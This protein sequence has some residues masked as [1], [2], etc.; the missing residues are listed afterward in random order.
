MDVKKI[1]LYTEMRDYGQMINRITFEVPGGA[2]ELA[3]GDFLLSNCCDDLSAK[4]S[5]GGISAVETA[6]DTVTLTT[7]WFLYRLAFEIKGRGAAEGI[8]INK[9][10]AGEVE[11]LHADWFSRHAEDGVNYRLYAP[12][13]EC[14][15]RPLILFLHGGGG[16]GEDNELQLTDT[17]GA[18]KLAERCPDMYV[19]APQAPTGGLTLQ[20]AFARMQAKGDP[21]KVIL[22]SD[23]DNEFDSRGWNRWYLAK[24]ADIIRRMIAGG[25]VDRRRVY[26]IGMSMGGGGTLKMLSVAPELFAAAVSICPSMNGESWP[27]LNHLP[28]VPTFL[29]TGYIDH[30]PSRHAYILQAVSDLWKRGRTD[31]EYVLFTEEELAAYGIGTTPDVTTKEL[32]LENHNSWILVLHNE[33]CILDWMFS[34]VK[35]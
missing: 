8:V 4:H 10:S 15:P 34:H 33:H 9:D 20:Q 21:Y 29:A 31:V 18:I 3:P 26:V 28:D 30:S 27:I 11:V 1:K 12:K 23:T 25:E 19:M 35:E 14:G 22:G 24:V 16:S 7:D 17:L 32:Y 5:I 6:G 2:P 13:R